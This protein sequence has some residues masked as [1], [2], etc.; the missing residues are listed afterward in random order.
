MGGERRGRAVVE[1]RA[2]VTRTITVPA[3]GFGTIDEAQDFLNEGNVLYMQ[4]GSGYFTAPLFFEAPVVT[5]KRV[6]LYAYD[7]GTADIC[8]TLVRTTPPNHGHQHM[9]KA[10]SSGSSDSDGAFPES[11]LTY[12]RITG[13]YGPYL[14]LYLPGTY[15]DYRFYG[16]KITY[17]YEA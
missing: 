14:W 17:T 15:G 7:S 9:G 1:P 10:C 3:G 5:V 16:A 2:T 4:V 6:T 13:A 11:D 8:V 12:R